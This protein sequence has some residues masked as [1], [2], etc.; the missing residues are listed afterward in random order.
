V[1]VEVLAQ[2]AVAGVAA[3]AG[4]GV[5][6]HVL[7]GGQREAADRLH[8]LLLGDLEAVA[9]ELVGAG[10]AEGRIIDAFHR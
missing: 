2:A 3:G 5:L 6:A 8:Q 4:A 9:D 1:L 7:E 10:L